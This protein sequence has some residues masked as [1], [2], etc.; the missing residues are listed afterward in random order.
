M[1]KQTDKN[2]IIRSLNPAVKIN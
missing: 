2:F 1:L